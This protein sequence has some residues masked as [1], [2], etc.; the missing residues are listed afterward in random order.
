MAIKCPKCQFENPDD[1][2]YCG[3]CAAPLAGRREH[4]VSKTMTI[5]HPS[6]LIT[7]GT[8]LAGKYRII[9]PIGKGGM[10]VVYKAE[11]IKLE[12]T[13]ALK[14]LSA[15][16]TEDPEARERFV[17]EAKAAA[18]LSHPHICTLYEI[19]ED[20]NQY[21]IAMEWIEGQSL[22]D[23]IRDG[24]LE[25]AEALDITI[26]VAEGLEEA[27]KKGIV[28][29][30]IKPGNIMVTDKGTA[31]VMDFGLA[32]VFGASII[33][34]EA[35]TIGTVAYMSPE[36]SQGQSVDHRTDI[37]SLGVVLYEILSG[38]LPFKGEYDQSMIHSILS[39]EPEPLTKA[40]P[41]TPKALENIV[42]TALAKRPADRYKSMSELQEDLRA[43][44]EGLKPLRA[45]ARPSGAGIL[46][47][48]KPHFYASL[49]ALF[50][51]AAAAIFLL[52]PRGNE[53]LDSV[54]IL[55]IINDSG[56]P[57]QE[58]FANSLTDLL[59]SE[60][61]KVAA[62]NVA[63]RQSVWPYKGSNKSPREIAD[64]LR[65]KAIVEASVLTSGDKVRLTARLW[66]P[67]K[68]KIIW[69]DTLD[70]KYSEIVILQ[71]E[72]CQAIVDGIQ[73][74]VTPAEKARLA[75]EREVIRQAY[76]LF[77]KGMDCYNTEQVR[78][79]LT[80]KEVF[81]R[82]HDWFQQAIDIDPTLAVAH[83]WKATV[84]LQLGLNGLADERDVYPKA[85]QAALDALRIDPN[86]SSAHRALGSILQGMDW[87]FQRAEEETKKAVEIDPGD[88]IANIVY[89]QVLASNG[90]SEETFT[91][92]N[93]WLSKGEKDIAKREYNTIYTAILLWAGYYKEALELQRR[94]ISVLPDLRRHHVY[95][96]AA[97]YAMNEMNSEALAEIEKFKDHPSVQ[98]YAPFQVNYGWTLGRCGRSK[99]AMEKIEEIRTFLIKDNIDPAYYTG[100]VYAGLGDKDKAF[101]YLYQ[102]YEK[103]STLM[104]GLI[105]DWWLRSL[106]SDPRFE[107]LA[108][109]VG[110]PVIPKKAT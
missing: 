101:E 21:F 84:L 3:K 50:V 67:Y 45:K 8:I 49:T 86:L 20:E 96:L 71:S 15:E 64:E 10:G 102:A 108:K 13:V 24:A 60:L 35:K 36:Q 81:W 105:S 63:S 42:L 12:R 103:R 14:F 16:L 85:K 83:A 89:L 27:H 110:F 95:L 91:W 1:A 29:R 38:Q 62:L 55:P 74:A 106:H 54:A 92:L 93:R 82:S 61:Y 98:G 75:A 30:D 56:D 88:P 80:P 25:Q 51:A 2:F 57:G 79:E 11:D 99:E 52:L 4:A 34:K 97:A 65:V 32:K 73:V 5:Q 100:C 41:T 87:D 17:R 31:K 39:R 70:R 47:L 94:I 40:L 78:A 43:V 26:Q 104:I 76:D 72:L 46:G 69:A 68:Q 53:V 44:A 19:G 48:R 28:H 22:K 90:K 23:K 9:E 109:K 33:T 107:E 6:K 66:D 18:A 59:I 37:W 58:Y 7:N 77:L